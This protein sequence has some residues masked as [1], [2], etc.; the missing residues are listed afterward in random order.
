MNFSNPIPRTGR[1]HFHESSP[2]RSPRDG[3][4]VQRSWMKNDKAST[5]VSRL[6]QNVGQIQR[7]LDRLRRR[8]ADTED[9]GTGGMRYAGEYDAAMAYEAQTVVTRGL[10]GEF[11][12]LQSPPVGTAP[13]TGAPYWH[14]WQWP[15]PGVWA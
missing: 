11:I 2:M 14:G 13:E 15:S 3:D 10:L 7:Q 1:P 4:A 8:V 6:S 9:A 12:S 5:Q